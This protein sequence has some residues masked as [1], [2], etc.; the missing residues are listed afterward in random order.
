MGKDNT[1]Y[2]AEYQKLCIALGEIGL[3]VE[4]RD[5]GS[6]YPLADYRRLFIR[7]EQHEIPH[8]VAKEYPYGDDDQ[9]KRIDGAIVYGQWLKNQKSPNSNQ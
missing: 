7:N 1:D 4:D 3:Y 9:I 8:V 2:K 5:D 6:D